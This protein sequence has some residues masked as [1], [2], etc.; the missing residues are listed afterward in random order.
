MSAICH[1]ADSRGV[2]PDS[3]IFSAHFTLRYSFNGMRDFRF[4][5]GFACNRTVSGWAKAQKYLANRAIVI[6]SRRSKGQGCDR[7]SVL[8]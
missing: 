4:A 3:W 2:V 1:A 8:A 6:G 7:Q 5:P